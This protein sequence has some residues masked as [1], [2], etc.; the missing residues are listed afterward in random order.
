MSRMVKFMSDDGSNFWIS[1][2]NMAVYEKKICP[3]YVETLETI[4]MP[5]LISRCLSLNI[6]H[7]FMAL[8]HG[9]ATIDPVIGPTCESS[10]SHLS[11]L[12]LNCREFFRQGPKLQAYFLMKLH[13]RKKIV[14][15]FYALIILKITE[16]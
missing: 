5:G 13:M 14:F 11:K 10:A 9:V 16:N 6:L 2:K 1:S 15:D 3:K 12:G 8:F 4:N 7:S